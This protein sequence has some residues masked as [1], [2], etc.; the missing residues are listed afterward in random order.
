MSYIICAEI[1]HDKFEKEIDA[2]LKKHNNI[3]GEL[4]HDKNNE[5]Y[6]LDMA[7]SFDKQIEITRFFCNA[8]LDEGIYEFEIM[9]SY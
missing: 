7:G 5:T 3:R 6:T 1:F 4:D 8:L 9:H 2:V